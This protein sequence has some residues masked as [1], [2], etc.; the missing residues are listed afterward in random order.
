VERCLRNTALEDLHPPLYRCVYSLYLL[1]LQ[2]RTLDYVTYYKAQLIHQGTEGLFRL[3]AID[4]VNFIE[5]TA[6]WVPPD[7]FLIGEAVITKFS[8][9]TYNV[10]T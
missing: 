9:S 6:D 3:Y 7:I 5:Q 4:I 1:F 2:F 10:I 8:W